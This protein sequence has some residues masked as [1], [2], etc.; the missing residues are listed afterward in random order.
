MNE[1]TTEGL[2][3][4]ADSLPETLRDLADVAL[5]GLIIRRILGKEFYDREVHSQGE[6]QTTFFRERYEVRVVWTADLLWRLKDVPGFDAFLRKNGNRQFESTH[7]ELEA[8]D[9]VAS[10]AGEIEFVV[11]SGI[12]GRD[13]DL[14]AKGL[15]GHDSVNVEFKRRNEPFRNEKMLKDYL[16][17]IRKQ[18][19]A[20]GVGV[21]FCKVNQRDHAITQGQIEDQIEKWLRTTGRV[22]YVA[23]CWDPFED[24]PLATGLEYV[25]IGREGRAG[26]RLGEGSMSLQSGPKFLRDIGYPWTVNKETIER[27][28]MRAG[29]LF[30]RHIG[31]WRSTDENWWALRPEGS[32]PDFQVG[33]IPPILGSAAT[34]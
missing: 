33:D 10:A 20:G 11:P 21:V 27:T 5:G 12:L 6:G 9:M 29:W 14:Q 16:S 13:F 8:S 31:V 7:F 30:V 25:V 24:D 3:A 22:H 23:L 19:P 28:L 1:L 4:D 34:S 15:W 17:G 26:H 2:R 18:L 32:L